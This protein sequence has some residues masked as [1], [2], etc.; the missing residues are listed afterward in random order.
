MHHEVY[1]CLK[2]LA[3]LTFLFF[4]EA[5]AETHGHT[6]ESTKTLFSPF[7]KQNMENQNQI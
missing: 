7:L 4:A 6:W 2:T 5:E 1:N 3:Y